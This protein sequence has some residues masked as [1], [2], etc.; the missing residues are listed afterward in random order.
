MTGFTVSAQR[1]MGMNPD[2]QRDSFSYHQ[3][4]M[5]GMHGRHMMGHGGMMSRGVMPGHMQGMHGM[6]IDRGMHHGMPGMMH[7][8]MVQKLPMMEDELDLSSGQTKKLIDL[9]AGFMRKRVDLRQ[10]LTDQRGAIHEMVMKDVSTQD[11]RDKLMSYYRGRIDIQAAAYDA[12]RQMKGVLNADQ[13]EKLKSYMNEC[14]YRKKD[15]RTGPMHNDED[16]DMH[17]MMHD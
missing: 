8:M 9:Q 15:E 2:T 1:H 5:R 4:Y 6:M 16:E 13:K 3:K 12:F 7:L 11:F 14:P 17:E 10:N